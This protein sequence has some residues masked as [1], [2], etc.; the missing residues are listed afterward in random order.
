MKEPTTR[1]EVVLL[2]ATSGVLLLLI[3]VVVA[4]EL[5][6]RRAAEDLQGQGVVLIMDRAGR[7][8]LKHPDKVVEVCFRN[9]SVNSRRLR[10]T[11]DLPF[12]ERLTVEHGVF[13]EPIGKE[14]AAL[15]ILRE[16]FLIDTNVGAGRLVGLS[17]GSK[18][19]RVS[20]PGSHV[21]NAILSEIACCPD[22]RQLNLW[23]TDVSDDLLMSLRTATQL[24]YLNLKD[25]QITDAGLPA[26]LHLPQLKVLNLDRTCV[27]GAG[28]STL[29]GL[30]NLESLHL[31]ETVIEPA[32]VAAF[33]NHSGV[34]VKEV[35][36][37]VS[38]GED[39]TRQQWNHIAGVRVVSPYW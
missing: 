34:T 28:L 4:E 7:D 15:P 22:L 38:N 29:A 18:L 8:P 30:S 32:E 16:L 25:T 36:V 12:V 39:A 2:I 19:Q 27:T 33:V 5:R 21:D 11:A 23:R 1:V 37:S 24:E 13:D 26:L 20:L 3:V 6:R 10:V 35:F 9:V 17:R 14:V 31:C